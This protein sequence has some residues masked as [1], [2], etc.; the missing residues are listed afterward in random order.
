MD[1][2]D[3]L[4]D[5]MPAAGLKLAID[6]LLRTFP[7]YRSLGIESAW[8]GLVPAT[9]DSLPIVDEVE[10]LPGL[11]LATGHVYGNLAGPITGRLV[12]ELISGE[13][14]SLS[15]DELSLYRPSLATPVDGVI[16][17]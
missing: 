17:Y 12:A 10:E 5:R 7:N 1:Y 8:A 11:I 2:P 15:L 9:A 13:K 14:L 6:S 3:Q 4:D 16:R